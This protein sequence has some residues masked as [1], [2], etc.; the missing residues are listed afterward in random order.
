V[1]GIVA[2]VGRH[3]D[4]ELLDAAA[5]AA[6]RRGPHSHGWAWSMP[7]GWGLA[8]GAG[9]LTGT[10]APMIGPVVLAHSRLATSGARPGD[11]SSPTEGQPLRAGSVV[12]AH[13][14]TVPGANTVVDSEELL[15]VLCGS[16]DPLSVRVEHALRLCPRATALAAADGGEV[17]VARRGGDRRVGQPLWRLD[18]GGVVYVA[19]RPFHAAC[20]LLVEGVVRLEAA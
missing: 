20:A 16:S 11:L 17:V 5:I 15:H 7:D 10:T 6:G 14:G 12:L 9:P 3:P 19:S 1:C 2:I 13:N 8:Y 18:A 4:P